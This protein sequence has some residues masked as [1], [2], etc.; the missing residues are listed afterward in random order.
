MEMELRRQLIY[1]PVAKHIKYQRKTNTMADINEFTTAAANGDITRVKYFLENGINPNGVNKYGRTALQ[2]MKMGCTN[3]CKLLLE[4]KANPNQQDADGIA[5]IH[6]LAREGH[7][8]TLIVL[9]EV[10][11]ADINLKD[12]KNK[13]V[14]D[15]AKE[16]N[17]DDVVK[18]LSQLN[19]ATSVGV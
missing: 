3:L 2:V 9:V 19:Q 12:G 4:Y 17:H 8:D 7:L 14:I 6:D 16:N 18:Y 11:N 1:C 5:L 10:G 15:L 13:R